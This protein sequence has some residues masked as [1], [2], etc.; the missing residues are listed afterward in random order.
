MT[1]NTPNIFAPPSARRNLFKCAPPP[2]LKS[3]IRPCIVLSMYM[4]SFIF[5][6]KCGLHWVEANLCRLFY[7]LFIYVYCRWRSSYQEGRI[8]IPVTD[9]NPPHVCAYTKPGPGFPT[10]YHGVCCVQC[11]QFNW[12]V[13]VRFVGIDI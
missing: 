7:R 13:I 8:G 5:L 10:S 12:E 6:I 11:V 4:L 2:N 3:W 1:Q 9:L